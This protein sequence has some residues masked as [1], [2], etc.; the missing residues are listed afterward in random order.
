[1]PS[2]VLYLTRGGS[3][4]SPKTSR[5]PGPRSSP[6]LKWILRTELPTVS[7][8]VYALQNEPRSTGPSRAASL[9]AFASAV[10]TLV[11]IG[12]LIVNNNGVMFALLS[13]FGLAT[14][15]IVVTMHQHG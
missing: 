9:T 3:V 4:F 7:Y 14:L 5:I 1:M 12:G 11:G 15:A 8:K 6:N 2:D 13:A 10:A